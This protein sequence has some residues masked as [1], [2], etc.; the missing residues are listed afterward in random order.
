MNSTAT[1]GTVISAK[2]KEKTM[3]QK[4]LAASIQRE[5]ALGSISPQYLND[6]E[7]D[8]RSPSSDFMIQQFAEVLEL[9]ADYLYFLARKFPA[10]VSEGKASPEKVQEAMVAFRQALRS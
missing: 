7:H 10:D 8:R 2:R 4:D 3:S 6:I 9:D 1:F 5:D